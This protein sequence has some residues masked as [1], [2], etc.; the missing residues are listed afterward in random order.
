MEV[1]LF[2]ELEA[3]DG[4]VPVP[5][6]GAKQRALLALLA[7]QRGQPVS[8]DRLIDVLWG[9]G[10]AA[11]PANALQAQI[12]QLRRTLGPAA[13]L[14]TEAGYAL[15]A[16]PDEVDVVRFEQLVAKGRRLASDGEMAPASAALGEALRLRRGEPLA[17]FTYAG[18][19]DAE[20]TRLDELTLVATESRAGADLG[21]GRYGELA[22]ELEALCREHPLRERLWELLILALYRSGRQAE[23]LRAYTEIRDRLAGEL[24]I[25][26]GPALRE[27]Q[28]RILVQDPSLG[29][30]SPAPAQVV[31]PPEAAGD[32][33]ES[34]VPGP[35]LETKLYVPRSRRDLVPR[36][37]LSERLDRGTAS[38]LTLVSAPAGFGKTTLLTE[39][40]AAGP[41]APAGEGRA[42]WLSL[43]RVDNDPASFW[44]YVIAALRTVASGVGE[45]ALAL[46]QAPQP[47]P[48]ETVLTALLN[49]LGATADDIVL[50]LDDYHVID[51]S[52][53]QDGMAFLLD[54]LPPWLHVVIASRADPAL[55]LARWRARGE[56]V[57]IRAA[58]LRFT[59][60]EAAAY[61]NEMMGLQLTAQDVAA[62]EA[63]TEGWIAALQLAALSMQGRDDVAGFIAGFAG[64]DRYVVDYLVEEVLQRQ[65]DRVQAFL[66]QTSILGRLSGPLCDAVTGQ[67]GG[68]AMLEALDRG[69]LFLVPLDDRRRWYRYHH[70]FADVLQARLLDEQPGQVPDL[71]RRASTWY[72]QNGEPQVAIGHALA[73]GDFGR[74]ADLVEL[75]IPA[76]RRTRQ[77]ATVRGWLK[78][79]PLEALPDEVVR[80]R[81]VLSVHFAG[82]LLSGGEFEGVEER[83]R[84]AERW[85][86]AP[87][88]R[89]E[90]APA[91]PAE[92]VV[93]DE[94]E[95]RRLPAEI[96]VYRAA[97]A[98]AQGDVPGTLRRARRALDLSP[99]DDHLCRASAAGFL[100]LASWASG[101]LEAGHS[102]YAEC[103]AGLRRAGYIADTFG[104]AIA[105]AD[106]RLAQG[107]LGEAMHTYEQ[108][109]QRAAE[110][111][112]PVLRGPADMYVGMSEVHRER[113][114]L[115]AATRQLLRSQELGEHNGLP[116]NRYRW[117]VAMARIRQAEGNLHGAL[118]LLNEAER[119]YVS[120]FFPNVRPVPAVKT[121]VWIAQG[122]LGEALGW[123]R[124]QGLSVDDDLSY[125]REFEHITLARVLLARYQD[126]R[127]E[128]SVHEATRLLERLLR[129][130][131]EG[132]RTGRVI[133]ILVLQALA[134]QMLGDIP[135][136]LVFLHR[137]VTLAEP[138]G[139]V[140]VFIDEGP[141]MTSLLRALAKQ[142]TAGNYV[143]RLLAAATETEHDGPVRQDF[144]EPLS[145]RELDV[146]RLL[147]TELDGPAIARELVVSLSTVRTHTKHI[148]AKLAV[149]SRRAAVRRAAELGL[150][151]IRNR[152]P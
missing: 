113:D 136:A 13:I 48:I 99:A 65:P 144:I 87:T 142:G 143:R 150:P 4:G 36:P 55:P 28:A 51:A 10:Q 27:L 94:E 121:R 93:A 151:P 148:Y 52:D 12:G 125:L 75:A 133:E 20:R 82:A 37:R 138:E 105:L 26:P 57:E 97:L 69:N 89:Y 5:V 83:L 147:G 131:E 119:L 152:Q 25:D 50:V 18:F 33:G 96:E 80:V 84:D 60:D 53:V 47:P 72:E 35:L 116:Q 114:D 44:T 117:R 104:C 41:D 71:H 38:K 70:L 61:L 76:M 64:D 34:L 101:D 95:Y 111:G 68:K 88:A 100:G 14:T 21:L 135:A 78:A 85:L 118:D 9:D 90:G 56:L 3:L 79:L 137:V 120:D 54:H 19:F 15:S 110:Q 123:A 140:R 31:A 124:E 109:L 141:P 62:L 23:A 67:G 46:L 8:A 132:G 7:L 149:T 2:G 122:R 30:A 130:A 146:L 63:R 115:P 22:G 126:E 49:D 128:A 42:A 145:E 16:G 81:P 127:A 107:R 32:L 74:A 102:A 39:W 43:D 1:R 91:R 58:E 24:G 106:I 40:L 103:M 77:E 66:L 108:A 86:D 134:H 17:E 29:Q 59:P 139:Y 112:G 6:R 98:L 45:S 129:A 11:N 73:A 92:M